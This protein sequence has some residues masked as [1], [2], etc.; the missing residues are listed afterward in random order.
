VSVLDASSVLGVLRRT[1][2]E[3]DDSPRRRAEYSYDA[4]NYRVPPIA[5]V[6]PKSAD[7][8]R[9][10]VRACTSAG[11][12]I[13]SRGGGTSMAGNAIGAG[14]VLD[15]SRHMTRVVSIDQPG[16]SAVVEP[17]IVISELAAAVSAETA[18]ALTYAPDPS[19]KSRATVGGAVGND[20]CGNHS[21]RYGRTADHT[22]ALVSSPW[23]GTSCVPPGTDSPRW[24][25]STPS[26]SRQLRGSPRT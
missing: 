8:V 15:F 12:P 26:R 1:D 17:G 25:R 23:T 10:V 22:I 16:K 11:V 7:E 9:T 20:A 6:F 18:G 19:S 5:V 14:V 2:I 4:S 21:V 3:V 24:T 13:V